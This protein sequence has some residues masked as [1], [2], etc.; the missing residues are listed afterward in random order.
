MRMQGKGGGA[1][2][3][4]AGGHSHVIVYG[5]HARNILCIMAPSE[6]HVLGLKLRNLVKFRGIFLLSYD[7]L[8]H[9]GAI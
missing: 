8:I 6:N 2:E 9:E 1:E 5:G 3:A 7:L 4:G